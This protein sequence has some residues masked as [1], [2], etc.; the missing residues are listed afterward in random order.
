MQQERDDIPNMATTAA[1][2]GGLFGE[3]Y[4]VAADESFGSGWRARA[5]AL[6]KLSEERGGLVPQSALA[7]VLGMTRQR[8]SQLVQ[9]GQFEVVKVED[10]P[11]IT[12]R[13]L[14]AWE[15]DQDKNPK[16]GWRSRRGGVWAK[17]IVS[18]KVGS[19]IADVLVPDGA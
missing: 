12:G 1:V 3:D 7:D 8:V 17:T 5:Q 14:D 18:F 6:H 19:A 10:V 11:F 2:Q 15:Q 13:S 4:E 16:G 9:S